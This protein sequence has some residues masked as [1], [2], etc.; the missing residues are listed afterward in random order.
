[1][2]GVTLSFVTIYKATLGPSMRAVVPIEHDGVRG[3]VAI[4][5]I[6]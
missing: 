6:D 4:G 2:T 1:V 3:I 5:F